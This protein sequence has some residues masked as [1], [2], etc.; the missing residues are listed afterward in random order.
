MFPSLH[1]HP[2][3]SDKGPTGPLVVSGVTR[4]ASTH[5]GT[6]HVSE[7]AN[8][9]VELLNPTVQALGLELLGIEYLRLDGRG[10]QFDDVVGLLAHVVC[11]V[12]SW[13]RIG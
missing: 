13:M 8:H 6:D 7:K 3:L 10:Q 4:S 9:I 2:A 5:H 12:V 11:A 1:R